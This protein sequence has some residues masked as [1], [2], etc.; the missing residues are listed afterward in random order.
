MTLKGKAFG[1]QASANTVQVGGERA[2]VVSRSDA[3]L[4][5][6]VPLLVAAPGAETPVEVHVAGSEYV[7]KAPIN[8]AATPSETVAFRFIAQPFE[9]TPGHDHAVLVTE[10]GSAG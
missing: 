1:G 10:L 9:D 5:V 6:V 2:L 7:G 3:E 8:L 4:K